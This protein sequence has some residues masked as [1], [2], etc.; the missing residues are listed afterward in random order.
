MP[1]ECLIRSRARCPKDGTLVVFRAR[2][3]QQKNLTRTFDV[4][5][6]GTA[7]RDILLIK[8]LLQA[9]IRGF[10][11]SS[12]GKESACNAGDPGSIP[13]LRRSPGEGTGYPLQYSCLENSKDRGA[14]WA[15]D[16]GVAD[17]DMTEAIEHVCM[18][19]KVII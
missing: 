17:L 4:E 15:T 3:Q 8:H 11:G 10:P 7:N 9:L 5:S 18:P 12:D 2:G 16:C 6:G 14:W 1:I 19:L 13:K